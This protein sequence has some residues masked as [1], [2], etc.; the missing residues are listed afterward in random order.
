MRYW[1]VSQLP[2]FAFA[3]PVLLMAGVGAWKYLSGTPKGLLRHL[4]YGWLWPARSHVVDGDNSASPT[5]F[6][7]SPMLLPHM[8]L[9]AVY[10]YLL[11][12]QSHTQIALRF[13]SPAWVGLWISVGD[14]VTVGD[15]RMLS[16]TTVLWLVSWNLISV[17]LYS[18]FLP[19]A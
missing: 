1:R 10:F 4:A 9:S 17:V 7:S 11:L 15:A 14:A 3:S 8:I 6:G 13:A 19:P 12:F 2:N 5:T 16:A 18:A